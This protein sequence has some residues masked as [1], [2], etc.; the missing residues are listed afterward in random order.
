[1]SMTQTRC[2][3]PGFAITGFFVAILA[4]RC[5][6]SAIAQAT[7]PVTATQIVLREAKTR[8][9]SQPRAELIDRESY[10]RR[11]E[12]IDVR[13][14]PD[15]RY[16]S[17][18]R[19][20]EKGLEVILQ[21]VG[22]G[23][24]TRVAAGLQRVET[25]WSGDGRRLWFADDQGLAVVESDSLAAKRIFKW[26][27]RRSQRFWAVDASAPQ[28]VIIQER[29]VESGAER[30]RYLSVDPQG[31]PHLLLEAAWPLRSILLNADGELA[32]TAA[33]DGPDYETVIRR[34]TGGEPQELL[35][36][37]ILEECRLVGY[38][39]TGQTLWLLS[40]RDEDRLSLRCWRAENGRW[41]T[42]HRDPADVADADAVLWSKGQEDWLAI[43]YYGAR[44][45]WYGNTDRTHSILSSLQL[46]LPDSNLQLSTTTDEQ[47]WLVQAQQAD[48]ARD[49]YYLY[50]QGEN[51]LQPLFAA[52]VA[53]QLTPPQGVPMHAVSYRASDGMLLHGYVALPS[54][55]SPV[56]AP[57]IAWLHGGPIARSYDRY[58]AIIQLLVNRGNAVF[59][60]NFRASAGYGLDYVLAAK[61]DVG[62]G[63]VLAD[64]IEGMDFL[65]AEGI[66]DRERQ[67]V[68]GMSFGGYASLLAISHHPDRFRFAFVG[69]PPTDYGW[70]K[71]WQA[72]HDSEAIRPQGPPLSLL[73]PQLGFPYNDAAWREK[74]QRESP[75]AALPDLKAPFYIW[76]GGHDETVPIKSIVHFVGEARRLDKSL[77]LLIDPDAGH[78]PNSELGTE[79]CV[80][81]IELASHRHLGGEISPVSPDL[82]KFLNKNLRIDAALARKP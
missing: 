38:S 17:F 6:Q 1:M 4:S 11:A 7:D 49:R 73:F 23:V 39:Q 31:K 5:A 69:A 56:N 55:I 29:V 74:M 65:L 72:E 77:C 18:V 75:V 70:I 59:V 40:R 52:E 30:F 68:M 82:Q 28:F 14:S 3:T 26:D 44:R 46:Q 47:L 60:P 57:L 71:Q 67:A 53:A 12:I 27:T 63:R 42:T 20:G 64:I 33:Y 22:S 34:Y 50:R 58:D 54:G 8:A 80:Y 43:A 15:G 32:F 36:S 9:A 81:L 78:V 21:S 35:R 16:L 76:A 66:G 41:E 45:G 13:L 19:R 62:N 48:V 10:L 24:Q 79:A 61:S 25:E 37:G 51:R 2:R